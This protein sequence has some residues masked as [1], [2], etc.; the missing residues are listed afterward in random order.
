MKPDFILSVN[1]YKDLFLRKKRG[2]VD[3]ECTK[4]TAP[5]SNPTVN[6]AEN[7]S[8]VSVSHCASVK[9]RIDPWQHSQLADICL[10]CHWLVWNINSQLAQVPLHTKDSGGLISQILALT[11][12]LHP[13]RRW[14]PECPL[15]VGT[16]L[17]ASAFTS[18]FVH[19]LFLSSRA[20][21]SHFACSDWRLFGTP[22][23]QWGVAGGGESSPAGAGLTAAFY[24]DGHER[25]IH[26]CYGGFR[27]HHRYS[28]AASVYLIQ[29]FL[30]CFFFFHRF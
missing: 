2:W 1:H 14:N 10:S 7:W 6:I 5:P 11:L 23:L 22:S 9:S 12:A 30:D 20:A 28:G 4:L 18:D 29:P 19:L 21:S 17:S 8:N 16:L 27:S 24:S 3:P 25:S 26:D 15:S 13:Q